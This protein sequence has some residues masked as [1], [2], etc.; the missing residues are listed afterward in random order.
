M[1]SLLAQ[2]ASVAASA[3]SRST[4]AMIAAAVAASLAPLLESLEKDRAEAKKR[5]QAEVERQK[6]LLQVI[7][8]V[9]EVQIPQVENKEK[10]VLGS[11]FRFGKKAVEK[12]VLSA[13]DKRKETP[14][15]GGSNKEV[16]GALVDEVRR[17]FAEQLIP[18]LER[19]VSAAMAQVRAKAK[20]SCCSWIKSFS[21]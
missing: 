18:K 7:T 14:S 8:N 5:Q 9:V 16:T 6:K 21:R 3:D 12:A 1:I 10:K 20:E 4:E 15:A 13:L 11:H 2:A 19:G 17:C